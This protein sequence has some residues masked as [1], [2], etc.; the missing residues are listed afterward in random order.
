[1]KE[2]IKETVKQIYEDYGGVIIVTGGLFGAYLLGAKVG[3]TIATLQ[4][5][6]RLN[7]IC[8]VKPEV[9]TLI[10]EGIEELTKN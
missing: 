7:K 3:N 1:M 5:D 10:R 8:K 4:I 9:E 2:K 6:N